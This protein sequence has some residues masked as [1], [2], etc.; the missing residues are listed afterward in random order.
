QT[1]TLPNGAGSVTFAGYE[2]WVTFQISR[3]PGKGIVLIAVAF[4]IVGLL[5]SLRVRRRR[6]WVRAVRAVP[7]GA[8]DQGGTVVE[9][10]G[11][12]RTDGSGDFD[13]DFA[14]LVTALQVALPPVAPV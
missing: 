10:G 13:D 8:N 12:T 2:Q 11:L 3:D 5:I 7:A 14:R 1:L 6:M 4:V 9:V